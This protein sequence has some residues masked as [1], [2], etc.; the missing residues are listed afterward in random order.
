M[1][2]VLAGTLEGR[3]TAALL[4]RAGFN[5]TAS[6][7]TGYGCHLLQKQGLTR[8]LTGALD[9][10]ALTGI[11]RQ[12]IRLL[13]DATHPFAALAS[14]TAM[15]AARAAGVPYLRLERPAAELPAHPLVYRAK[16]LES[17]IG[18]ALSLG[19]VLFSTLGSKS[20][21]SLLA[22]ARQAGAKVVARVLPDSKVILHCLQLGLNPGEIIALQGPCSVELNI[23]LYRQY[24]AEVVLTKDSGSTGGVE[25]KVA[26]A[27]EAG[28]PVV[29]WQR[30]GLDY[31]LVLHRPEEVLQYCLNHL[32]KG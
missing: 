12:G 8:I 17:T 20:L 29:V 11:L 2:L 6:A 32:P 18:Q 7:V 21:S 3:D 28:I 16:D 13:V 22:A 15:A 31:P 19:K 27:I 5:V 24:Q 9:E 1:I 14:R 25:E 26:A 10:A 4:Q 23:A 30:P